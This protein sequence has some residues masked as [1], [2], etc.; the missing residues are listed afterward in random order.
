MGT[1]VYID[2]G[3]ST[4]THTHIED[5]Y[6][7][8]LEKVVVNG[9]EWVRKEPCEHISK[10]HYKWFTLWLTHGWKCSKCGARRYNDSR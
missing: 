1:K 4:G 6:A 9:D 2:F 8:V 3:L 10:K 5:A 7:R